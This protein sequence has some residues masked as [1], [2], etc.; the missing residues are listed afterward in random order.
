MPLSFINED[1]TIEPLPEDFAEETFENAHEDEH[2]FMERP[3]ATDWR[4][5]VEELEEELP[6]VTEE[7][8]FE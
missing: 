1:T 4:P 8:Q 5:A 3:P 6:V 7:L 2:A